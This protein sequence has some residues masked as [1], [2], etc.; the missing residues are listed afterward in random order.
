MKH[1]IALATLGLI[2]LSGCTTTKACQDEVAVANVAAQIV[3][4]KMACTN[5]AQ[6][7]ADLTTE[8]QKV[9]FC[10]PAPSPSPALQLKKLGQNKKRGSL[11]V[12]STTCNFFGQMVVDDLVVSK[13]PST[14]GCNDTLLTQPLNQLLTSA[15]NSLF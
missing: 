3:A 12:N 5:L 1:L 6:V 4:F 7:E 13:V 2:A 8:A 15:C 10:A 14:W 9:G 11:L